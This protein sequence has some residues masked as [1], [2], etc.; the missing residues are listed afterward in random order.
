MVS[1]SSLTGSTNAFTPFQSSHQVVA[2]ACK[3]AGLPFLLNNSLCFQT[4]ILPSSVSVEMVSEYLISCRTVI[5]LIQADVSQYPFLQQ[6]PTYVR[7]HRYKYWFTEVKLDGWALPLLPSC[8]TMATPV[9]GFV[10]EV[11][12]RL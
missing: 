4:Y 2:S 1:N 6:P 7:A 3:G 9:S 5:E 11:L 12:I 8:E 10:C